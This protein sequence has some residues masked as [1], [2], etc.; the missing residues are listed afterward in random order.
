MSTPSQ[1]LEKLLRQA[2]RAPAAPGTAPSAATEAAVLRAWRQREGHRKPEDEV[3]LLFRRATYASLGICAMCAAWSLLAADRN[4]LPAAEPVG[5][6][7][8][9]TLSLPLS[10]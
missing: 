2:G 5:S 8:A 10:P 3:L 4:A 6:L 9:Y 7:V 1:R